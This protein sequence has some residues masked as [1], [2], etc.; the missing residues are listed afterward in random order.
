MHSS[1]LVSVEVKEL[2]AVKAY[3]SLGLT[4]MKYNM[5]RLSVDERGKNYSLN[6]TQ[7]LE[8]FMKLHGPHNGGKRV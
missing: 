6:K 3:S 2:H 5:K 7:Q 1:L 8:E 4:K